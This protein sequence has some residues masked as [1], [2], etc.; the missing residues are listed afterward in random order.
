MRRSIT[1]PPSARDVDLA[2]PL[3]HVDANMV[4]GWPLPSAAL[5]ARCSC[6]A[7]YATT[8]SERPAASSHLRSSGGSSCHSSFRRRSPYGCSRSTAASGGRA[9][10][11]SIR[12]RRALHET[13]DVAIFRSDQLAAST[14]QASSLA[15]RLSSS[16]CAWSPKRQV[17]VPWASALPRGL[18]G[19]DRHLGRAFSAAA[20]RTLNVRG[21][22]FRDG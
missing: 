7:T 20:R 15:R 13:G 11:A 8:S 16:R 5:T 19:K 12:R 4:H 21:G 17:V 6:G 1:S 9:R 18:R 10:V 14:L 22:P 2:F 3:V